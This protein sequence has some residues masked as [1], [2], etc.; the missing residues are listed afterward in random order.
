VK[1]VQQIYRASFI[2][3]LKWFQK[4]GS[5][6]SSSA[7]LEPTSLLQKQVAG[8]LVLPDTDFAI[9]IDG[10]WGSGK[11]YTWRKWIVPYAK[12]QGY[13]PIYVSLYGT[14][15]ASDIDTQVF[16]ALFPRLQ[17]PGWQ[18]TGKIAEIALKQFKLEGSREIQSLLGSFASNQT[19]AL[20]CFDDL[21]RSK[22]SIKEIFG[23]I[24]RFVEHEKKKVII[25]CYEDEIKTRDKDYVTT[26]EKLIGGTYH[27]W[28]N[29]DVVIEDVI[30]NLVVPAG[31]LVTLKNH[32]GLIAETFRHSE[33]GNIRSLKRALGA[34]SL[35]E[36]EV[37]QV[38]DRPA[39]LDGMVLKLAL[40]LSF[41]IKRDEKAKTDLRV[42]FTENRY[43]YG[44]SLTDS[45]KKNKYIEEFGA[46][47]YGG[48]ALDAP[49]FPSIFEYACSGVMA[50]EQFLAEMRRMQ[51]EAR[52]P[53]SPQEKLLHGFWKLSDSELE[54]AASGYLLKLSKDEITSPFLLL[55][56]L[57]VLCQLS[58]GGLI[59]QKLSD[60]TTLVMS[61]IERLH[62]AG[63]LK[64]EE[65]DR[66][67]FTSDYSDPG[68][69][70][71]KYVKD[72]LKAVGLEK[73]ENFRKQ[74]V[75]DLLSRLAIEPDDFIELLTKETG[76]DGFRLVPIL[77]YAQPEKFIEQ[78]LLLPPEKIID[79]R[80]AFERRYKSLSNAYQ[81]LSDDYHVLAFLQQ[82]LVN[83]IS[84]MERAAQDK[85][86][87]L[88]LTA[89]NLRVLAT[90]VSECLTALSGA[91]K[92]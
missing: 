45:A 67:E 65:L 49:Y 69:T 34:F 77:K 43:T 62:K 78:I 37:A 30:E 80:N 31:C 33:S 92:A 5:S 22:L 83:R 10:K 28:V 35:I 56:V 87:P 79:L 54:P 75:S 41:E 6:T 68:D 60:V 63:N 3:L 57:V 86:T 89:H 53:T 61:S 32:K 82:K 8:Y 73:Q 14:A 76:D 38:N 70:E 52:K 21:E 72:F 26:K 24:N 58:R 15:T 39:E 81:F 84:D 51:E 23:Y 19:N 17:G 36:A 91:R 25:L 55:K 74:R 48:S 42:L 40:A 46:K 1:W 9:M 4:T 7:H 66:P 71:F 2:G 90:T 85:S 29:V 64:Y 44:G 59:Q 47:Y 18:A 13:V 16:V 88:P 50:S 20:F 11:T 12:Q 27:H